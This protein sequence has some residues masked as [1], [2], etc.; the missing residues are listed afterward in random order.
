MVATLAL[1]LWFASTWVV[2][3]QSLP[4]TATE[5]SIGVLVFPLALI[6]GQ[7]TCE[8]FG[9]RRAGLLVLATTLASAAVIGGEALTVA[10]YPVALALALV[11]CSAIANAANLLVFASTRRIVS[12]V[13]SRSFVATPVALLAG[14][15]AF[16]L[17]WLAAGGEI[18]EAIVLAS[19]PCL[20]AVACAIVGLVPL[21]IAA[22]A[23]AIYLRISGP[24]FDHTATRRLPRALIVDEP[25]VSANRSPVQKLYTTG[26][27]RFFA[28]GDELAQQ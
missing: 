21:V 20:Y 5:L 13:A 15:S 12:S 17:V 27:M 14:W 18:E 10:R 23:L 19:T 7:L 1:P 28:E 16:T 25:V 6:A 22:R 9:A 4:I 3:L 8:L 2:D 24:V 11:A 26:E